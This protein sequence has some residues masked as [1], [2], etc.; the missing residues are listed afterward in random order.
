MLIYTTVILV[1]DNLS[2]LVGV[3]M[4]KLVFISYFCIK[5]FVEVEE[6][7]VLIVCCS[8]ALVFTVCVCVRT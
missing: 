1:D 3:V 4:L 2:Q 5:L 8:S 7:E 6:T